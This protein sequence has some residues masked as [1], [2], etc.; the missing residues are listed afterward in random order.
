MDRKC[1]YGKEKNFLPLTVFIL[2]TIQPA[3]SIR[4]IREEF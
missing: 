4:R 2:Q 1:R 3:E